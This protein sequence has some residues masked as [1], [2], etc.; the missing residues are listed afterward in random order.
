MLKI[1][2]VG[3]VHLGLGYKSK[4]KYLQSVLKNSI[5]KA[6]ENAVEFAIEK[7][8]DLFM[9]AGDLFDFGPISP[10]NFDFFIAM[11]ERL[12]SHDIEVVYALGNHDNK[13]IFHPSLL[14][15][16][17]ERTIFFRDIEPRLVT[18]DT[19]H[20]E[21]VSICGAGHDKEGVS[22]NAV[23]NYK[24]G[25]GKYNIGI[26][27]CY[28]GG[29]TEE[30]SEDKYMPTS[31]MDIRNH[32]FDYFA[33]GHIHKPGIFMDGKAAYSGS[34]QGLS[35]KESGARGG[36]YVVID[37]HG[38]VT[39]HVSFQAN[40]YLSMELQVDDSI[41]D[42]MQLIGYINNALNNL[43][44]STLLKTDLCRVILKGGALREVLDLL[45]NEKKYVEDQIKES[46]GVLYVEIDSEG[47][48]EAIP[49][50]DIMGQQHFLSY[51]LSVMENDK[52]QVMKAFRNNLK[53]VGLEEILIEDEE[54]YND[55]KNTVINSLYKR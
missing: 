29:A 26:A 5:T 55:I 25:C 50:E 11:I 46:L 15:V 10:R 53:A 31:I 6:F 9:I 43:E 35:F 42:H 21:T 38:T 33:M 39:E 16:L 12:K 30:Y 45:T 18:V 37:D 17:S 14:R 22:D 8:V 19:K 2:H 41:Q 28:L 48:W 47:I 34:V 13:S 51:C 40:R 24:K 54:A 32:D 49:L 52:E 7:D 23:K 27:H 1:L 3:D 36:A 4:D 44:G 20:G